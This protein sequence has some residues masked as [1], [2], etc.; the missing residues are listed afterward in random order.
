[1][2][3]AMR[4][5]FLPNRSLSTPEIGPAHSIPRKK[6]VCPTLRRNSLSQT[7]SNSDETVRRNLDVSYSQAVHGTV[8]EKGKY[9]T[10][11]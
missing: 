5:G 10:H 3:I 7:R 8:E 6:T 9:V 1:M 4:T 2:I 11:K